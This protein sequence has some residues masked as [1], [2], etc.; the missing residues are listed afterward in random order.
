MEP[1]EEIINQLKQTIEAPDTLH[2]TS[3]LGYK[4]RGYD[5]YTVV[6][7]DDSY[8]LSV[9]RADIEAERNADA[10]RSSLR[11]EAFNVTDIDDTSGNQ[12]YSNFF[13]S[14]VFCSQSTD[15]SPHFASDAKGE[16]IVGISCVDVPAIENTASTQQPFYDSFVAADSS[17]SGMDKY[18]FGAPVEKESATVGYTIAS[19]P[20][21]G[22]SPRMEI[23]N[24]VLL[25]YKAPSDEDWKYFAST[26]NLLSCATYEKNSVARKAFLGE[27]CIDSSSKSV[28]EVE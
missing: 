7:P 5:Y 18:V 27:Q 3:P 17:R 20:Y 28:A 24:K 8:N 12:R 1:H 21:A 15:T 6:S 22:K 25:F 16:T 14:D 23:S 10:I 4:V 19:M 2:N 13:R 11:D 9:Q 26:Q